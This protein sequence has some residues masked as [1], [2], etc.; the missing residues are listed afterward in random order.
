MIGNYLEVVPVSLRVKTPDLVDEFN[1]HLTNGGLACTVKV[2]FK[3]QNLAYKV[4]VEADMDQIYDRFEAAM[5]GEYW[6]FELD[7]HTMIE[8][9]YKERVIRITAVEDASMPQTEIDKKIQASFD[10][11]VKK[12]IIE[13]F[14]D[15]LKLP[16]EPMAGR[17]QPFSLRVDY[18]HSEAHAHWSAFLQSDKI[19]VKDSLI[20][21][22]LAVKP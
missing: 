17:G 9:L 21:L 14:T 2:G 10:D 18:R 13:L 5:H 22:R 11:V 3:A 1:Y 12:I 19:T 15:P 7:I 6:I 16:Q 4:K 8:H 20:S